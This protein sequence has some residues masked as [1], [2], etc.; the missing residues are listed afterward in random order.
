MLPELQNWIT[1]LAGMLALLGINNIIPGVWRWLTNRTAK[2]RDQLKE[3]YEEID[4]LREQRDTEAT[5]ARRIAEY[6]SLLRQIMYESGLATKIP[7]W[8]KT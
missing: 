7:D 1:F 3:A 2:E 4:H 8:P 6:A 5:R